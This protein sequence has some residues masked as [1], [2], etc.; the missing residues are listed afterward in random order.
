MSSST[1][2][3]SH[4]GATSVRAA[5]ATSQATQTSQGCDV[6]RRPMR[7]NMTAFSCGRERTT[8]SVIID[9][10]RNRAVGKVTAAPAGAV[11]GARCELFGG[12]WCQ[13]IVVREIAR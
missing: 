6:V 4:R 13:G 12:G 8:G 9:G 3:V 5:P 7:V 11:G 1:A 10:R 2:L